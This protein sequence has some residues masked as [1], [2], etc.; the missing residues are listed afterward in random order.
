MSRYDSTDEMSSYNLENKVSLTIL[1]T[2][3]HVFRTITCG[4]NCE[5]S[6]RKKKKKTYIFNLKKKKK[7]T[8]KINLAN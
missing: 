1:S 5:F 2:E 6:K 3:C 7:L 4:E 8:C